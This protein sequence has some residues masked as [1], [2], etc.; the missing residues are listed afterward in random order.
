MVE[1]CY[2]LK[3]VCH[4][5]KVQKKNE[6]YLNDQ[7][8]I[9]GISCSQNQKKTII[10]SSNFDTTKPLNSNCH[11]NCFFCIVSDKW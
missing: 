1:F 10:D 5:L 4:M 6:F 7:K 2:K 8:I 3:K 11:E 9:E